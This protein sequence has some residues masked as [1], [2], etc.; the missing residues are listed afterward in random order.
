[1]EK[2]KEI[3]FIAVIVAA[4]VN[5]FMGFA[6]YAALF[7]ERWALLTNTPMDQANESMVMPIIGAIVFHLFTATGIAYLLRI[8]KT[9]GIVDGLKF[10]V[11]LSLTFAIPMNI[12]KLLWQSKPE[13]FMIDASIAVIGILVMTSI[14]STW[15]KFE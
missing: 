3:K 11:V 8:T 10:G 12:A 2:L 4:L 9:S 7:G 5:H 14:I 1:M 15:Q 13:L 6:W